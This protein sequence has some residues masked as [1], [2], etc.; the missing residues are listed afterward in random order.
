MTTKEYLSQ[1]RVIER[2]I[3]LKL[4]DLFHL[5]NL[6]TSI[7]SCVDSERVQT[8]MGSGKIENAVVKITDLEKEV[9]ES[10]EELRSKRK[11]IEKQIYLLEKDDEASVLHSYYLGSLTQEQIADEMNYSVKT[12][13][14]LMK[15]GE[16]NFEKSYG[17]LYLGKK[18]EVLR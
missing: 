5:H 9:E 11:I 4:S 1:A 15:K 17:V 10:V 7:S 14:N 2:R 13:K 18:K 3:N 8:S 6:A 16:E 12:I